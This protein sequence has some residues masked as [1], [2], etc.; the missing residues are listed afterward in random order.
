MP[1]LLLSADETLPALK[2]RALIVGAAG[3][4]AASRAVS[5]DVLRF[6]VSSPVTGE[7]ANEL[8]V[9]LLSGDADGVNLLSA[10]RLE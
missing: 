2:A 5:L 6:N 10:S 8:G 3:R 1:A 9:G 7:T 4:L